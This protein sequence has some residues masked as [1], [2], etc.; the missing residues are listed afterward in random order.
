MK[1][2][3]PPPYIKGRKISN[4]RFTRHD[5]V[6]IA[7]DFVAFN[8]RAEEGTLEDIWPVKNALMALR[9]NPHIPGVR[10]TTKSLRQ[11]A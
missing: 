7:Q 9:D 11:N 1:R 8:I 10:K 6:G 4:E 5:A 2:K 3:T